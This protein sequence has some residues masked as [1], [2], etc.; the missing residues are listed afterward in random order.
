MYKRKIQSTIKENLTNNSNKTLIIEGA[1]QIEIL[2]Y[3]P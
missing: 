2:H 3:S 1:R